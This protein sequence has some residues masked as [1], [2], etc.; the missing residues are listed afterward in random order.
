M[1]RIEQVGGLESEKTDEQ[2]DMDRMATDN[3]SMKIEIDKVYQ[4]YEALK[5]FAYQQSI[6]IPA[7]LESL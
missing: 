7:E 4:N 3:S 2:R 6:P 1:K 5:N